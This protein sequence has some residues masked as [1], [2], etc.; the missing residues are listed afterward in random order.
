MRS[1]T[2]DRPGTSDVFDVTDGVDES[3]VRLA[4]ALLARIRGD[5]DDIAADGFDGEYA[6]RLV[7]SIEERS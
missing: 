1:V 5:R 4:E 2:V 6:V 3:Y 7:E